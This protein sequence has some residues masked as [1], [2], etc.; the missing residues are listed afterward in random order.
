VP[1]Y[2]RKCNQCQTVY[3]VNCKISEKDN[4]HKCPECGSVNGD[5]LISTP[6]AVPFD[7][8]GRGRDGGFKEVLS[9]I[10]NSMPGSTLRDR[11]TF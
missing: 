1:L 2:D 5:W 7:R 9:K 11:N 6:M 8:L 3:E 4:K 10:H